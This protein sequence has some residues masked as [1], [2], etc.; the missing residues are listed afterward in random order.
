[1]NKSESKYFNTALLMDRALIEL[2]GKKDIAY[3]SVKEICQKAGVNRSTFYLHYETIDDLLQ[4]TME[5]IDS[6]FSSSFSGNYKNLVNRIEGSPLTELIFINSVYL[7]PYL[8]FVRSNRIIYKA[9]VN[10]PAPMRTYKRYSNLKKHVIEPIMARFDVP[11]NARSYMTAYYINGIWA[12]IQEWIKNDCRESVEQLI[13]IIEGCVRPDY[14][15][16]D[17]GSEQSNDTTD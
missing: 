6:S 15:F 7:K 4:E 10:N 3:I 17:K 14:P 2:L 16:L 1:M 5:Y 8:E 11:A 13:G 9:S 12:I